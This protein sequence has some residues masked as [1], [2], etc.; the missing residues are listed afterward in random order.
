M[1][2]FL[3]GTVSTIWH[4]HGGCV[5][6]IVVDG[7]TFSIPSFQPLCDDAWK[8][9]K[10]GDKAFLKALL[11]IKVL[12]EAYVPHDVSTEKF[13]NLIGQ[14]QATNYVTFTDDEIDPETNQPW[15]KNGVITR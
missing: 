15:R 14:I 2:D 10:T 6:G 11:I 8:E 3:C 4:Y 7:S 9:K 13:K 5:V 12:N 1:A